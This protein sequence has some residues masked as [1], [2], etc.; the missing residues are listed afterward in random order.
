MSL[1]Q[2]MEQSLERV[3][4]IDFFIANQAAW[5]ASCQEAYDYMKKGFKG[6]M[7]RQDDVAKSLRAVVEIDKSLRNTLDAKKLSQKYWIDYFNALVIDRCWDT[8]K[9]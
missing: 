4:L 3:K 1:T 7:V 9:K 8:L 2:Q 5:H 6:A